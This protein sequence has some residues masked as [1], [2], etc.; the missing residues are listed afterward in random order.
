MKILFS[1][2]SFLLTLLLIWPAF[3]ILFRCILPWRAAPDTTHYSYGFAGFYFTGWH[4][5]IP[6]TCFAVGAVVTGFL[7]LWILKR[8]S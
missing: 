7:G 6:F 8:R 4:L 1:C 3:V 2:L 5:F